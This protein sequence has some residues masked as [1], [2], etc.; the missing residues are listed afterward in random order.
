M[1]AYNHGR[2][3]EVILEEDDTPQSG[4]SFHIRL[5]NPVPSSDG[6]EKYKIVHM[7]AVIVVKMKKTRI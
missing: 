2:G 3:E 1:P 4:G 5:Y 6:Q 7:S